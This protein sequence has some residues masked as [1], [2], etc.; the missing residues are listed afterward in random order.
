MKLKFPTS[1]C[2][3]SLFPSTTLQ[4]VKE[5]YSVLFPSPAREP[6]V[7]LVFLEYNLNSLDSPKA[8]HALIPAFIVLKVF[9]N[10]SVSTVCQ[11]FQYVF[12]IFDYAHASN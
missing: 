4:N 10:N 11:D 5:L 3:F 6:L 12:C 2:F 9:L 7:A 1:N 8:L